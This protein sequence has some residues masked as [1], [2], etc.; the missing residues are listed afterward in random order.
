[1]KATPN[2]RR[3]V[4]MFPRDEQGKATQLHHQRVTGVGGGAPD[5]I[6]PSSSSGSICSDGTAVGAAPGRRPDPLFGLPSGRVHRNT[7]SGVNDELLNLTE[8]AN[9]SSSEDVD[10]TLTSHGMLSTS[11]VTSSMSRV[12]RALSGRQR[13]SSRGDHSRR[14]SDLPEGFVNPFGTSSTGQRGNAAASA[15]QYSIGNSPPRTAFHSLR[16]NIRSRRKLTTK[17][18][19]HYCSCRFAAVSPTGAS[20]SAGLA[21]KSGSTSDTMTL[22]GGV[23][24]KAFW[25]SP[26]VASGN[27]ARRAAFAW[28]ITGE[29]EWTPDTIT[30]VDWKSLTMV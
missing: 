8:F 11:M 5:V 28:G 4:D 7:I 29:Q 2:R 19:Y 10:V 12:Q 3:W 6:R 13:V 30:R 21:A 17:F 26:A 1:M 15:A 18:S 9:C 23:F 24:P 20:P 27:R 25:S 16:S 14:I 22:T